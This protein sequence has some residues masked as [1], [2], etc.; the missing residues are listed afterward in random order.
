MGAC[1]WPGNTEL[2]QGA[3]VTP[4]E[5]SGVCFKQPPELTQEFSTCAQEEQHSNSHLYFLALSLENFRFLLK[6]PT[7]KME[8]K[9][10]HYILDIAVALIHV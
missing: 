8:H 5:S 3:E 9:L 10:K 4:R 7:F 1:P 6:K 2:G